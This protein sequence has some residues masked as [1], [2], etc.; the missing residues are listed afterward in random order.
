MIRVFLGYDE[1]E[2]LPLHVCA[3][4][5]L[6]RASQPVSFTWLAATQLIAD[7]VEQHD[8]ASGLIADGYPPSNAFIFSRFLVPWLCGFEGWAIFL[9]GD[10]VVKDDIA[11]LW[12]LRD[13]SKAVQVV[14]HDYQTKHPVKYFGQRNE[15]YPR[16]MWSSV[17]LWNCGHP[18]NRILAPDFVQQATGAF[19]HRFQWLDDKLIG[20]LPADWNWLVGEY[21]YNEDARLLHY[22]IGV[23]AL[24]EYAKCD[25]ADDWFAEMEVM[26]RCA[27]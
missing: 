4:S 12:K 14:K 26:S 25:H 23:P 18:R 6:R 10:M 7:Y 9:D 15:D 13:P 19:L 17:V 20:D 1:R 22:T 5:I 24:E 8:A 3:S 2:A 16:K 27:A 11:Q 21:E